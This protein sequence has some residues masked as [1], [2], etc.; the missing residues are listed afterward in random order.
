MKKE[1]PTKRKIKDCALELFNDKGVQSITTNHIASHLKISPGNLYYHY[2]NKEAIIYEIYQEMSHT[3]ESFESF[4]KI[5]SSQNP[6]KM[7]Y[8]MFDI[9]AKLFWNYRFLMRDAALLMAQDYKLK[10]LFSTN[11]NKRIAQIEGLLEFFIV[12]DIL[13]PFSNEDRA[14]QAK[15][16]WFIS[17]YWQGFGS[18]NEDVSKQSINEVKEIIV[19]FL[20]QPFLTDKGCKLLNEFCF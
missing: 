9:Y 19:K 12:Q 7:L 20:I 1:S 11:Q 13:K 16:H 14:L 15:L 10:E 17:A 2:K 4:E 18:L 3:F 8:D 5:I 6:L